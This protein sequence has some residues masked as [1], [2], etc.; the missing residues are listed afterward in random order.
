MLELRG[1][2]KLGASDEG[3]GPGIGAEKRVLCKDRRMMRKKGQRGRG[4]GGEGGK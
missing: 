4:E 1:R 2:G 3:G